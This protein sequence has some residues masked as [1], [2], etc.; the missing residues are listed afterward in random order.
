M[1]PHFL[2]SL[3]IASCLNTFTT[4]IDSSAHLRKP[5][6]QGIAVSTNKS[7]SNPD[8]QKPKVYWS[9]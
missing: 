8:P 6:K 7:F 1:I 5:H 3:K 9:V 2:G 4:I